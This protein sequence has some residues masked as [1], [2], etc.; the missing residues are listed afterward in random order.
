M[1]NNREADLPAAAGVMTIGA[2]SRATNI[3]ANTLRTWERRYGF[4]APLRSANNQ[5]LYDAGLVPHLILIS[6]AL[7]RGHR[8]KQVMGLQLSEL[9]QL[10]RPRAP[11]LDTGSDWQLQDWIDASARLDGVALE[12]GFRTE[13]AR[14]GAMR[15][16]EERVVPYLNGIGRA[17]K[18][19]ELDVFHEHFATERLRAF[20]SALWCQMTDRAAGAP[21]VCATLPG[22]QHDLGLHLAATV[23][24]TR[25]RRVVFLGANNPVAD[26][27]RCVDVSE[28]VAVVLSISPFSVPN[29]ARANLLTLRAR[30]PD[31]VRLAVGGGGAPAD[32]PDVE[33]LD[34]L[35][36]LA[37]WADTL[38]M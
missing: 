7:S 32:A 10:V 14:L 13:Y 22:E 5:R 37:S 3:P 30:L 28:S 26:I 33:R 21:I 27:E 19:Q 20:L 18:A 36:H 24:S 9:K 25:A 31:H 4:P 38:P 29:E 35:S 17:W 11:T 16:L 23:L 12:R 1:G 34:T 15:F 8:P 6:H 2:I